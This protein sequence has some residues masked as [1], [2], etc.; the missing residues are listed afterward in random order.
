MIALLMM[1]MMMMRLC[2]WCYLCG[3]AYS[4]SLVPV[5]AM[6][7]LSKVSITASTGDHTHLCILSYD[8]LKHVQQVC[9]GIDN[10]EPHHHRYNDR[11]EGYELRISYKDNTDYSYDDFI[12]AYQHHAE[13][14]QQHDVVRIKLSV[15]IQIASVM[16]VSD[17]VKVL[18]SDVDR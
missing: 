16:S 7:D 4:Q 15:Q 17:V 5:I 8:E 14:R 12:R 13:D 6:V 11:M 9:E 2:T 1:M 10:D 3:T 18:N